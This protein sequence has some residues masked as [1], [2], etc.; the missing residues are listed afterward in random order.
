MNLRHAAA[1]AL[2]GWYLLAPP[3]AHDP[4]HWHPK[5][6][7][8]L[9]EWIVAKSFDSA[10]ECEKRLAQDNEK[11]ENPQSLASV[12]KQMNDMGGGHVWDSDDLLK[13][14]MNEHA[15]RPT[16]PASRKSK[17]SGRSK[18]QQDS[19]DRRCVHLGGNRSLPIR[20]LG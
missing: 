4:G 1:L 12:T 5:M 20:L 17:Q 18:V 3:I 10:S 9:N 15:L 7:A 14:M 13:E 2:V 8:P 11:A 16:T 6:T 19:L